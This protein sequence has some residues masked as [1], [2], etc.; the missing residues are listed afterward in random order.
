MSTNIFPADANI[1]HNG[2]SR[3]RLY[4]TTPCRSKRYGTRSSP[5]E[6]AREFNLP[7]AEHLSSH[8]PIPAYDGGAGWQQYTH[9]EGKSY[10]IKGVAPRIITEADMSDNVDAE[11]ADAFVVV[12]LQ[13][14][15][16]RGLKLGASVELFVDV[17]MDTGLCDYYFVD[18]CARALFWLEDATTS[19]LGLAPA[20]SAQHLKLALQENYWIH[21]EMFCM[22]LDSL[23]GALEE[24]IAVYLHA[25]GDLATSATSTFYFTPEV[26]AIH[27]DVLMQCRDMPENPITYAVIGRLWGLI[28]NARFQ[29]FYGEEHCRLDR[30]TNVFKHKEEHPSLVL[31]FI[32]VVLF[33]YP[34][35][36]RPQLNELLVDGLVL[37]RVL[38]DFV[39]NHSAE[40]RSLMQRSFGLIVVSAVA[41]AASPI[42]VITYSSIV[43]STAGILLSVI[44]EQHLKTLAKDVDDAYTFLRSQN[45]KMMPLAIVLSLPRAA[46]IWSLILFAA[47][48]MIILFFSVPLSAGITVC[49]VLL[50]LALCVCWILYAPQRQGYYASTLAR[51]RH[52]FGRRY[53]RIPDEEPCKV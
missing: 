39:A 41:T 53:Q 16:E 51:L 32:S 6:P 24:L 31:R 3:K 46:F 29:N 8:S 27:L 7:A 42:P 49:V 9:P 12:I 47:Q 52:T 25:R 18:H 36:V 26:T 50:M 20:C 34:D 33:G 17:E 5:A 38:K 4:T 44:L 22:H 19:E 35:A 45:G 43:L 37:D 2:P 40:W 13:W 10:Y 11:A 28:A 30:L 15:E 21:V 14:A 1:G 23:P 48:A